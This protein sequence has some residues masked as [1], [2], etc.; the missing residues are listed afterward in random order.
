MRVPGRARP[1]L[2]RD[3]S[4]A[5]ACRIG[6]FEQRVDADRAGESLPDGCVPFRL[7]SIAL[8]LWCWLPCDDVK[9]RPPL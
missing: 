4:A 3:A 7:I 2:E 6:R 8:V 5:D 1:G 9:P